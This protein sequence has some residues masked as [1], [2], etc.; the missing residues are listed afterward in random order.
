VNDDRLDA[1]RPRALE[2]LAAVEALEGRPLPAG[3]ELLKLDPAWVA[4]RRRFDEAFAAVGLAATA[5]P[6][7]SLKARILA[8]L[9]GAV[10][11]PGRSPLPPGGRVVA[12]GIEAVIAADAPWLASPLPGIEYKLL[13]RDDGRRATTRLLRFSAGSTYP[14]HCHGGVEEVFVL[15]GSVTLNGVLLRAGDYC[16]AEAGTHEPVAYSDT[17]G[18]AVIVSSDFDTFEAPPGG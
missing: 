15:E 13:H 3:D 2:E 1:D 11:R 8:S 12:P 7:P 16:R 6:P 5:P 14:A 17:G 18:L 9:D 4:L 10:P